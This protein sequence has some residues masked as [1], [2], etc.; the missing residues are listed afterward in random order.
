MTYAQ[1]KW[2]NRIVDRYAALLARIWEY[3]TWPM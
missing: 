3:L 2:M 1:T